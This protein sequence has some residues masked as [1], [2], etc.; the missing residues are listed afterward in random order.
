MSCKEADSGRR[1]LLVYLK[2]VPIDRLRLP[3]SQVAS[4]P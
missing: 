2:D 4:P 1:P 3:D